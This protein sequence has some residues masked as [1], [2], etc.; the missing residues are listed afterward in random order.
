MGLLLGKWTPELRGY[1]TN[2]HRQS[3]KT[4]LRDQ[5][6]AIACLLQGVSMAGRKDQ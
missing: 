2:Y 1:G 3:L 4:D 6:L 5:H